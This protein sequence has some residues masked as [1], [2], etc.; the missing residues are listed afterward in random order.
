MMRIWL[1]ALLASPG[2]AAFQRCDA[3][4]RS[5]FVDPT[6]GSKSVDAAAV[7][8][9]CA[10]NVKW[11]DMGL[12][13]PVEGRDAVADLLQE[14][15]PEGSTLMVERLADGAASGGFAWRRGAD[16]V[17]GRG[18]RGVTYFELDDDGQISY[19][20]EGYEPIFKLGV[21]LE[22]LFKAVA[23]FAP[24]KED[25]PIDENFRRETPTTAEG[26][27]RYLWDVAYPNGAGT[28]EVL[29]FFADDV[30]YE[31]FNYPK[32]FVGIQQVFT[33]RRPRLATHL[34]GCA[35]VA[36]SASAR[37]C[38]T[39]CCSR[40]WATTSACSPISRTSTL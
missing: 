21:G 36:R 26:I 6:G 18:L 14:R 35:G 22:L 3:L 1:L 37:A 15:Y 8:A 25:K 39:Y 33:S 9:A 2:A 20:Q 16:G 34:R 38:G 10:P 28:S 13:E 11:Y 4:L 19:V 7:A 40:R 12:P 30:V 32:P 5:L 27:V 24:P 23:R 29:R 17:D 31:D